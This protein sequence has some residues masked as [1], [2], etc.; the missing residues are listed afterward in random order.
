MNLKLV[1][2]RDVSQLNSRFRV[3]DDKGD[4]RWLVTGKRTP[5]G[6]SLRIRNTDG[7]TVCRIRGLGFSALSVYSISVGGES[8]RLNIAVGT[9]RAAV[10]FRGISFFVRGNVLSGSYSFFD[11]DTAVVCEVGRDFVK[12]CTDL[13][14]FQEDRA[15]FCIAA[16]ACIESLAVGQVPVLQMT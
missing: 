14:I 6:E 15:L 2:Q 8:I 9:G 5:S 13:V 3:L 4:P 16:V 7:E 1:L 12:G 11:A 10:R